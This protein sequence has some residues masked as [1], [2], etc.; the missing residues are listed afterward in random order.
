MQ[1][2]SS[3]SD[4]KSAR[5]SS[6]SALRLS[7]IS[8]LPGPGSYSSARLT[9][10]R[11][12]ASTSAR[13]NKTPGTTSRSSSTPQ[14]KRSTTLHPIRATKQR[15]ST[16]P[17]HSSGTSSSP[18]RHCSTLRSPE[19]TRTRTAS[20]SPSGSISE[21][22]TAVDESASASAATS[23]TSDALL[24]PIGTVAGTDLPLLFV[25]NGRGQVMRLDG[26]DRRGP[27]PP[28]DPSKRPPSVD[29]GGDHAEKS[30]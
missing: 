30:R 2:D 29:S 6:A 16:D 17:Q 10:A 1:A 9:A 3:D 27:A 12:T 21:A 5:R 20:G 24:H 19:R 26:S 11:L 28:S 8:P 14:S 7:T 22:G 25:L 13:S 18:R 4:A 15:L 23:P